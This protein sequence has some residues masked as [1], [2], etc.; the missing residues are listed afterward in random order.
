MQKQGSGSLGV[1]FCRF[2]VQVFGRVSGFGVVS[3]VF[4][5]PWFEDPG[6]WGF[7]FRA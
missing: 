7:R 2:G 5:V 1:G 3:L 6:V 4:G